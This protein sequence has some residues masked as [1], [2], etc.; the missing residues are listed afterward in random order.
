MNRGQVLAWIRSVMEQERSQGIAYWCDPALA[1]ALRGAVSVPVAGI[2]RAQNPDA[3]R[4]MPVQP[5]EI[6]PSSPP[7]G[8]VPPPAPLRFARPP[9]RLV[10]A[11]AAMPAQADAPKP[12]ASRPA[13]PRPVWGPPPP[14]TGREPGWEERLAA[15]QAEA[16]KCTSCGLCEGRNSVVFGTGK[17]TVPLVFVGEAP[18]AEEDRQGLP[19]VGRAGEL[20]TKIIA[21]IGL[22]REQ[23]YICNILKCRPPGNRDP[24]PDEV[25]TCTPFLEEQLR[26]LRPKL[27][28][29]LGRHS[30]I[31]LTGQNVPMKAVRGQVFQWRGIKVVPTYHPAALL[32]NPSLKQLVWE[33]VQKIRSLLDDE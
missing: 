25:A 4:R 10:P 7:R 26:L 20:L 11:S 31:F 6:A 33:D 1:D 16:Q 21:A 8:A 3:G 14:A 32:R 30:T 22:T 15:L 5:L 18:G 17:A 29:A 24:L 19:F 9:A 27:I 12:A 2:G 13:A 28:C 23:V